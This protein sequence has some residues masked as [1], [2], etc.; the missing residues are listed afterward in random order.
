MQ[1]LEGDLHEMRPYLDA[2]W[3][4]EFGPPALDPTCPTAVHDGSYVEG[5]YVEG[6]RQSRQERIVLKSRASE[7]EPSQSIDVTRDM[8]LRDEGEALLSMAQ[9]AASRHEVEPAQTTVQKSQSLAVAQLSD[10]AQW[11]QVVGSFFPYMN[12]WY[13]ISRSQIHPLLLRIAQLSR[14]FY[15]PIFSSKL[16]IISR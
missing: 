12:S 8:S 11:L 7:P 3:N 9:G 14:S 6:S 2:V 4:M 15:V 5:S 13:E 1:P 16:L 10:A